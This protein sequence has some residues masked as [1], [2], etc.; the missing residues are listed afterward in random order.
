MMDLNQAYY[1]VQ[2]VEKQGFSA[3]ARTL[4]IP[5]SRISRQVKS[6]E[7]TLGTRLLNRD[8]RQMSLTEAGEAY[9]RH[10]RMALECMLAAEAAVRKDKDALEGTVTLSSSVGVAQFALSRILPRF[11]DENPRVVL[12][13]QAS[14][15]FADMIGDGIDLAIRGH[16]RLLPD[17]GLIQRRIADVPWHLFGSPGLAQQLGRGASPTDLE[18]QPGLALGWRPGGSSWSLQGPGGSSA[19]VP[20]AARMRSDDMVSLKEAAAAGLGVV[21]LP[22]YVCAEEVA[23]GRLCRLLPDWVAGLPEIS[24]LMHE[25]RGNP[26][27]VDALA[28]FLRRELPAVMEDR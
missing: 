28:D 3:A 22:A 21:A 24:L 27:Q 20:F 6:L 1:L 14:N 4:G 23:A 13:L 16:V 15:D 17:S 10:A 19:S 7:E 26:P 8:S 11:L 9:Y 12:R 5:K 2:V 25:R 18:G